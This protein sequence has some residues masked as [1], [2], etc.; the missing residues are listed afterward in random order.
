[1]LVSLS[2]PLNQRYSDSY[3]DC[4]SCNY[5]VDEEDGNVT[6][7]AEIIV[8]NGTSSTTSNYTVHLS[9]ETFIRHTYSESPQT[10]ESEFCLHESAC[11]GA[12]QYSTVV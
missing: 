6:V 8:I 7:C 10:A 3:Y 9:A 5:Y 1:M 4:G 11:M 12:I 2:E